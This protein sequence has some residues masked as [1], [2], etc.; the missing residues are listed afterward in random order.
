MFQHSFLFIY[1]FSVVFQSV[2][3]EI[4]GAAG[5]M[6]M[7][8]FGTGEANAKLLKMEY[9]QGSVFLQGKTNINLSHSNHS[10]SHCSEFLMAF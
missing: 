4:G 2:A 6:G 7:G 10:E 5:D 1:D 9:I 3:N 8:M